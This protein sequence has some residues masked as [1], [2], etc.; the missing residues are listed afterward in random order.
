MRPSFGSQFGLYEFKPRAGF[1]ETDDKNLR[2][3]IITPSFIVGGLIG[4]FFVLYLIDSIGRVKSLYVAAIVYF[5]GALIQVL[6]HEIVQ[7][8]IGRF[9]AG[10]ASAISLCTGPLYIAEQSPKEIRGT[11]GIVNSLGLQSGM[12]FASLWNTLC[13]KLIKNPTTQWKVAL[14]GL[15]VPSALF[16]LTVW[17]L[18]ETPRYLLM[19]NKDDQAIKNLA[20]VRNKNTNDVS[21]ANEFNDMSTKLK[22]ELSEGICTWKELFS[23][24]TIVYRIVIVAILQLLHMLVGINAISYYSTQVY[25]KYLGISLEKYGAWLATLSTVISFVFT[26]PAMR[27]IERIGRRPLLK[28][29]AFGL[30][31]CMVATYALCHLCDATHKKVFG[32]ICVIVIYIYGI[33]YGWSWSSTI[34]VFVAELFPLRM[35]AKANTIGGIFQY[36]GSIIVAATTTTLMKYLSFYT[37]L[38]YAGFSFIAFI[39]THLCVRETRGIP[40]ED[41]DKLYGDNTVKNREDFKREVNNCFEENATK[42]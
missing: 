18:K 24:K 25:S 41:M 38:I 6:S 42:V 34:F 2:E 3:M 27:Y 8:C 13:L 9:I 30:G 32:W 23:T 12:F 10:I 40:L 28:W 26:F 1:I 31:L 17:F 36:I 15:M 37:F 22:V 19:K 16:L 11:L 7:L 14:A 33:V 35:R 4:A 5:A 21:V 39:F 20:Y 29:G